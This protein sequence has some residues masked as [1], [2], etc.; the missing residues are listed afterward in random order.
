MRSYFR[1]RKNRSVLVVQALPL[2]VH[3]DL[4]AVVLQESDVILVGEVA[5]LIAV[6]DPRLPV[7]E[8][9]SGSL[10]HKGCGRVNWP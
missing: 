5:A 4:H 6:D 7:Q 2:A 9:V 8:R 1:V 10:R 3:G